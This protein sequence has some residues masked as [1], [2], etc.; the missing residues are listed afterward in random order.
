MIST[1]DIGESLWSRD[2][3][4]RVCIALF[5]KPDIGQ[6]LRSWGFLARA[7]NGYWGIVTV[8]GFP[9]ESVCCFFKRILGNRYGPGVSSSE[10]RGR[11]HD[12]KC[13]L[14][15]SIKTILGYRVLLCSI[16]KI[17]VLG[18]VMVPRLPQGPCMYYFVLFNGYWGILTVL[19]FPRR[20][21]QE[22]TE[23][24]GPFFIGRKKWRF[25]T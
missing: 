6:S 13:A 12:W 18:I 19:G 15:C 11:T 4:A 25:S 7:C 17:L 8:P 22:H 20:R 1:F 3:L 24:S 14:L 23:S 9:R 10:P 16:Q 21:A 2:F 5:Y